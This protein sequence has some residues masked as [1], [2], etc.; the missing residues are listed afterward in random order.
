MVRYFT[1]LLL[2]VTSACCIAKTSVV[3]NNTLKAQEIK[4]AKIVYIGEVN[5][6]KV[7]ELMAG[8]DDINASYPA[9][10]EISLYI[11]SFGGDMEA[12]YMGGQ[13]VRGSRIP[14]KTINAAMTGSAATL[15]YC[16]GAQR[17]TLPSATF[18][19]HPAASQN[20]QSNYL[21]KNEVI[22]L[23]RD[24]DNV[25]KL[26]RDT[27][28]SCFKDDGIEIDKALFSEDNRIYLRFPESVKQGIAQKRV[29]G[30][31][32]ADV[33]YYIFTSEASG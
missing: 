32:P 33:A 26:F 17:E 9:V 19:I 16:S 14:I 30:I 15:I 23:S 6:T 8:I 22:L 24:I 12:G 3:I 10:K 28:A 5:G 31:A 13:A 29:E 21:K 20:I 1:F 27:Y 18:L 7:A 2:G 4:S 25:S 11:N